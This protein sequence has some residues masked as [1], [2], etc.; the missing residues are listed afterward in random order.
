[1]TENKDIPEVETAAV[2]QPTE[3]QSSEVQQEIL[4]EHLQK[5]LE[6]LKHENEEL[7]DKLLRSI[8][9]AENIRRRYE[10]QLEDIKEY[11][12]INFAKDLVAVMDNLN[13]ALEHKP[14]APA[15]EVKAILTGVEMTK[16]ELENALLKH[17][18][19][20]IEPKPGAKFDYNLHQ[21]ISQIATKD[22][23]PETV[24]T[25][26]QI[27]YQLKERLLRPAIVGVAKAIEE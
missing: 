2:D 21:A 22:F 10:K 18:V 4:E 13:R 17:G 26:M 19:K 16:T 24:V 11:A 15:I 27:G 6:Q 1:M 25:V 5:T 20:A 23:E 7:N 8:A 3:E 12:I 9:E 14:A